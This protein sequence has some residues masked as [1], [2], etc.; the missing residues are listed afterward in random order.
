[1]IDVIAEIDSVAKAIVTMIDE[2]TDQSNEINE[3]AIA[4]EQQTVGT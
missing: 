1:M 2:T 4:N 3:V